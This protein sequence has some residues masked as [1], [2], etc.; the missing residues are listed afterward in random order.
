[1]GRLL[2]EG[3]A[4]GGRLG[5]AV[6]AGI[7]SA[8]M[9]WRA[10]WHTVEAAAGG[11]IVAAALG[12][13]MALLVT[14]T[15]LRGRNALV[16][17]FV[18]PLLVPPQVTAL[19]W[20][21]LFGPSSPVL[22][23]LGMAPPVGTRNPL[24]SRDG[25][26][27]LLGVHYAPLVFLAL[28]A[29]ARH[30]PRDLVEAGHAAGAG[31]LK[32]LTTIIVPLMT[33]A[34]LAGVTL[35][36]VSCVGNFGIPALLGIPGNYTVL[37]TLIYQ[38]L[39]GLGTSVLAEVSALSVL[40][41]LLALGGLV[42]Q[43]WVYR[44]GD[45]RVAGVSRGPLPYPLGRWRVVVE[46][47][48]WA[49]ILTVLVLPL[50]ALVLTSLLPAYGVTLSAATATL[51]NY[52]YVILGHGATR[53]AFT[54][55]FF[56]A[57]GAAL[58]I[59]ALSTPLG[60]F[61]VWR[62][63]AALRVLDL[64]VELP[65]A[66]PGVVLAIACILVFLKPLPLIGVSVYN[67]VW[68]IFIAYVMR[69][70]TLGLRPVISGF[71]QLDRALDEAAQMSGAALIFRLRTIVLPL[72][73]PAAA[74]G[75]IFVFLTAFNELTVSALLWS[76]GAETLGVVVFGLEQGGESTQAAAVAVLTVA[77][78]VVLMIAASVAARRLPIGVIPWRG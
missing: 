32:V 38:R 16:F 47:A 11:T 71:H 48:C 66:L 8:P 37:T 34:L 72:V 64:A 76:S 44:R 22:N 18:L 69:F 68:I 17:C 52:D 61:L 70:L 51:A 15:D 7:L 1:M 30:L 73:A 55:S 24:Y 59:V 28:R 67:T 77:V 29:G 35:T 58:V 36:F 40:V 3:L 25:I 21:Q 27:L 6:L 54:N 78:T 56:L 13:A 5:T 65:Y 63:L 9:T 19:A 20:L 39:A 57:A 49:V 75:A 23:L 46:G 62:R 42:V 50:T 2:V 33:P 10:A 26:I 45:Y 4:P 53:R 41:G 43:H 74:A 31:G 60:Y 12:G 14:L